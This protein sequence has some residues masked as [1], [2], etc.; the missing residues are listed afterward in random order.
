MSVLNEITWLLPSLAE[1]QQKIA[2]YILDNPEAVLSMSSSQ[3]AE[4]AG[5]A[6]Q[7]SSS[8]ARKSV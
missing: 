8:L 1:N 5:S 4:D 2:K 3:F 7:P 6:S